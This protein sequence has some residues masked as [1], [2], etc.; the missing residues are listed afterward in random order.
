VS[1]GHRLEELKAASGQRLHLVDMDISDTLSVQNAACFISETADHLDLLINNAAILGDIQAT[2][3]DEL[4]FEEILKVYNVNALGTLR[5]T[6]A[7]AGLLLKG[8]TRLVVDI[9]S[10]AGSIGSC[11]RVGWFGYCM[12]KAAINMQAAIIHNS[13]KELG[14]QVMLV[15]P[16]W[17]KTYMRGVL[18]AEATL[19][20]GESAEKIM[21]LIADREK[22]RGDKPVYIDVDGNRLDW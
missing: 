17:M 8:D 3:L 13:L 15:H 4:D 9:S 6:N 21:N 18:D 20:P 19:Q 16:G 7:L 11:S 10:E 12:S 2:I 22:Y 14:G 5:V 1:G